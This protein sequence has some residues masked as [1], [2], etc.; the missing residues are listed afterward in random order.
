MKIL[1]TGGAGFIAS[2]VVDKYIE[3]G[4]EVQVVDDLSGGFEKNINPKAKFH[5]IDIRTPEFEEII[6]SEKYDIINHHAAQ[7]SVS[8]S[9]K[10]PILDAE[11]NIIASLR[12]IHASLESGV[13]KIIYANTGG[14]LFGEPDSL[15]VTEMT[16]IRPES[17]YG[18][19]KFT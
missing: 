18:V 7:A 10:K 16:Q 13:K 6:K 4:H 19:S 17:P 1:V 3:L 15:P 8:V 11:S 2:H 12:M 5:K 14:A 9:V